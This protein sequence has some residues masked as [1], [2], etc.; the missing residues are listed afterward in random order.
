[1]QKHPQ[2]SPRDQP[3][4]P[5]VNSR[6]ERIAA[7]T[8]KSQNVGHR[9]EDHH[10]NASM[11]APPRNRD[12]H[13]SAPSSQHHSGRKN[14]DAVSERQMPNPPR[15][16][17]KREDD[18]MSVA[19]STYS[20]QGPGQRP[21]SI[22]SD[23]GYNRRASTETW[24]YNRDLNAEKKRRQAEEQARQA[25]WEEEQRL[26]RE[27]MEQ[28]SAEGGRREIQYDQYGYPIPDDM[29]MGGSSQARTYYREGREYDPYDEIEDYYAEHPDAD[30]NCYEKALHHEALKKA[31]FYEENAG[32]DMRPV[33]PREHE[34]AQPHKHDKFRDGQRDD[35]DRYIT[36]FY[37]HQRRK[38]E[39]T[40][41]ELEEMRKNFVPEPSC[42]RPE[43]LPQVVDTVIPQGYYEHQQAMNPMYNPENIDTGTYDLQYNYRP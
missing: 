10:Q 34:G 24:D 22:Y 20:R 30:A 9:N 28:E 16:G 39:Y 37:G 31:V 21:P 36:D 8:I 26:R 4:D 29:S 18:V 2:S 13:L 19:E 12:A 15:A 23:F 6:A 17:G 42:R 1:M 32:I 33:A 5:D 43:T 40:Q 35:I 3:R 14:S 11:E 41:L 7:R 27:Q 38:G 25:R